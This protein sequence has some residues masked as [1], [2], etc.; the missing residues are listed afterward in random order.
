M[1]KYALTMFV[2]ALAFLAIGVATYTV[3]PPGGNAITGLIAP[4]IAALLLVACAVFTLAIGKNRVL[5]MIGIH[6]G[7]IV[8]LLM[9]L[10]PAMRLGGSVAGAQAFNDQL[11]ALHETW[12]D[13]PIKAA[14]GE[15]T[16]NGDAES[17]LF[18]R[19]AIG[20]AA[21]DVDPLFVSGET[22]WR[23]KG[24]QTVGLASSAALGVFGFVALLAHRPTPPARKPKDST[25]T[26]E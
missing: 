9:V 17:R 14:E 2:L 11:A 15:E 1:L 25:L 22:E 24:Y 8:P 26:G 18:V 4:G 13:V 5:G 10:G 6:V 20:D 7:L 21:E 3:T 12:T 16:V 23:P 19:R